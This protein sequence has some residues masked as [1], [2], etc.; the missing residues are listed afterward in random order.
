MLRPGNHADERTTPVAKIPAKYRKLIR[1]QVRKEVTRI[2][3]ARKEKE[4]LAAKKAKAKK[5]K[6]KKNWNDWEDDEE[7][8]ELGKDGEE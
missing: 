6:L 8:D 1:L 3:E 5:G 2:N 7:D 4:K